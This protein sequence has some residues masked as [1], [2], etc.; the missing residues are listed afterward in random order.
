MENQMLE[1]SPLFDSC[2]GKERIFLF[3]NE[4][5]LLED[6]NERFISLGSDMKTMKER[7]EELGKTDNFPGV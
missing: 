1:C 4:Y 6:I 5:M 2:N 3:C 7:L